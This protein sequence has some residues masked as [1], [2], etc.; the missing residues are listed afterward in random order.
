M[1]FKPFTIVLV[2]ASGIL[3]VSNWEAINNFL[4][5]FG[6]GVW[7]IVLYFTSR[8]IDNR[9][10][11]L[12]TWIWDKLGLTA[13]APKHIHTLENKQRYQRL[14]DGLCQNVESLC[15]ANI[16]LIQEGDLKFI[17]SLNWNV[18]S[19]GKE[20]IFKGKLSEVVFKFQG[21]SIG[22][23]AVIGEAGVGK[24]SAIYDFI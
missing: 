23:F 14:L 18:S 2:I 22:N 1:K 13:R 6:I 16:N 4:G 21:Q 12:L 17:D 8:I 7:A 20:Y 15:Q 11:K 3:I 5:I 24:T 10:D 19:K 9:V